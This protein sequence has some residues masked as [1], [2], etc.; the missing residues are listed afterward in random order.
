MARPRVFIRVIELPDGSLQRTK[1]KGGGRE[2]HD[3]SFNESNQ[4]YYNIDQRTRK[5]AYHGRDCTLAVRMFL[6]S[7]HSYHHAMT[8]AEASEKL[9]NEAGLEDYEVTPNLIE[10]AKEADRTGFHPSEADAFVEANPNNSL[11]VWFK[12]VGYTNSRPK[13]RKPRASKEKLSDCLDFWSDWVEA[14]PQTVESTRRFFERFVKAIGNLPISRLS[15]VD[16]VIWQ[17]WVK[18][19]CKKLSIKTADDHHAAVSKVLRLAKRKNQAWA[20]PDG[21]HEWADDWKLDHRP[22]YVPK[23]SNSQPMPVDVFVKLLAVADLWAV[24][25]PSE[26]DATTQQ[27]RGKKRQALLKQRQGVQ[28]AAVLRLAIHGL[29]NI[30]CARIEWADLNDLDGDL[31]HLDFPRTKCEHKIGYA[32]DRKT[33]LLSGCV[34]ALNRWRNFEKPNRN[35]FRTS[36]GRAFTSNSLAQVVEKMREESGSD[37]WSFKHLRNVGGTLADKEGMSEMKIDRFLGHTL[38]RERAKYLGD[39]GPD[40][41]IDLVNL[42]GANYFAGQTVRER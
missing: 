13:E 12:Q 28:F 23:K 9:T 6:A 35:V 40:Y 2:I 17:K 21:M 19:K 42:I 20:F 41:L 7:Q 32:V 30:D 37:G 31:P 24:T 14:A 18:K 5:R 27:G 1:R 26:I 4:S 8:D 38:K 29:A 36:Q 39:V 15:Q 16:F 25:D 33:P 34:A 11:A 22:K 10:L 3:L